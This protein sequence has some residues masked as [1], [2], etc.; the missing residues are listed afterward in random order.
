MRRRKRFTLI[1]LLVVIAIIAIL[2]GMLLPAL[3]KSREKARAIVCTNNLKQLGTSF[4]LYADDS[5]GYVKGPSYASFS[6]VGIN[7]DSQYGSNIYIEDFVKKKSDVLHCPSD[8]PHPDMFGTVEEINQC[9]GMVFEVTSLPKGITT[10]I[11]PVTYIKLTSVKRPAMLA[12]LGDSLADFTKTQYPVIIPHS[13][14]YPYC[15]RHDLR[16]NLFFIDG[17]VE[18]A[19]RYKFVE[20]SKEAEFPNEAIYAILK[21]GTVIPAR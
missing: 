8:P 14:N 1:E 20:I 2:A 13:L 17:H 6:W 5:D 4:L 15:I 11:S 9:Y 19:D 18:A 16:A 3:N 21:D 10:T 7:T 12:L